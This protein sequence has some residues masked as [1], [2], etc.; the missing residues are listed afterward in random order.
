ME[1]DST[2]LADC[3]ELE[4]NPEAEYGSS[5]NLLRFIMPLPWDFLR[6]AAMRMSDWDRTV[7][8][9][10]VCGSEE[11]GL[12][13]SPIRGAR[14]RRSRP[15]VAVV[16]GKSGRVLE[17]YGSSAGASPLFCG[18]IPEPYPTEEGTLFI[19][20]ALVGRAL[21]RCAARIKEIRGEE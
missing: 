17:I 14:G 6:F 15:A 16:P 11:H 1:A 7:T 19:P 5:G 3:L 12:R 8:I 10:I 2:E 20:A 21:D 18:Y 4:K 13:T 9:P